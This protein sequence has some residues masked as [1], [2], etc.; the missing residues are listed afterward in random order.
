[1]RDTD[2]AYSVARIR[3][4]ELKLLT[5]ADLEQL[6]SLGTA[7]ECMKR[8]TDKGYGRNGESYTS[9]RE[10]LKAESENAWALIGEIA[11]DIANFDS[12][13]TENDYHDLKAV[14]ESFIVGQ[15]CGSLLLFPVTVE[16]EK[17]KEAVKAKDYALLP[18][19]MAQAA[20]E[21]YTILVEERDSQKGEAVIDRAC[22]EEMLEKSKGCGEVLEA[23]ARHRVST[24]DM[25]IAW[26]CAVTKR[27][28][29]LL[30]A[31]LA[32]CDGIDTDALATAAV[33]GTGAV[34]E[35][36]SSIGFEDAAAQLENGMSAFEKWCDEKRR[37]I[38]SPAKYRSLGPDPLAAY[39]V[40]KELEIRSVR[41]ILSGKRNGV[42]NEKMR[43][44]LRELY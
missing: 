26:R 44:R 40:A 6:L 12:L 7:E 5:K 4:N 15:D 30:K 14:L 18:E 19:R 17:M 10:L 24:T 16:P 21:A 3:C 41:I 13:K 43:A 42:D 20:A 39:L 28:L 1:M 33:E 34:T 38:I 31:S 36:L 37:D 11:P 9:E 22:M 25:K 27:P 23:L 8:L 32:P 35:Y 2:Y 29:S